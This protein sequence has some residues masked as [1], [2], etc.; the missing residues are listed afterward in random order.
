MC[1]AS[2]KIQNPHRS[3]PVRFSF[4]GARGVGVLGMRCG[5]AY[6]LALSEKVAGGNSGPQHKSAAILPGVAAFALEGP[7]PIP[8]LHDPTDAIAD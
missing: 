5:G 8:R 1:R 6:L 3:N 7:P 2:I 4:A